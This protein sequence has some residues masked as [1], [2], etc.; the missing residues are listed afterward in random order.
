MDDSGAPGVMM[1]SWGNGV[2][3]G[4]AVSVAKRAVFVAG[5]NVGSGPCV[6]VGGRV[7]K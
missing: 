3:V 7:P 5:P 6:I 2:E 4:R 1:G